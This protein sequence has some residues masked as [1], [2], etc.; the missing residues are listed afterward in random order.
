MLKEGEDRGAP[1]AVDGAGD[2]GE[3]AVFVE[4]EGLFAAEGGLGEK[5]ALV[6][7]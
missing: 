7:T 6:E 2:V 1:V 3:C 4:E 5:K